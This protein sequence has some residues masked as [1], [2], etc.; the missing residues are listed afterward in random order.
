M[1]PMR[2]YNFLNFYH[3]HRGNIGDRYVASD[4]NHVPVPMFR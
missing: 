2:N 1:F 3:G 4:L